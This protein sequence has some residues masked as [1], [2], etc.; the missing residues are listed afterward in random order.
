MKVF[1]KALA[2]LLTVLL[3]VTT[4]IVCVSAA[5][6]NEEEASATSSGITVHYKASGTA[7]PTIYYWNSLPT[8][9]TEPD[10]PG[11]KM[12]L[13]TNEGENWY[14]YSF[15]DI[16]KINMLFIESGNQS[17]ELT[18]GSSGEYWYKDGI[19]YTSNPEQLDPLTTD[20]REDTIYFVITTRFYDGDSGN[21]VHCWDDS[22]ANNPDSDPA[23]RGDFKGLIEKLDYI[24][25]LGFSAIWITPVVTNA[26]GYDYHGY[27]AFDF[28]T[29]DVRYESE[30]AT[31]QDLINAAHAKGM[32]IVQDVV[33]QHTGNFGEKTF[34]NLFDKQYD[35]IQDLADIETSMIP[36]ET[37]L[38]EYGL[39]SA[40]EYYAQ[41]PAVQHAERLKLIKGQDPSN[42]NS[43]L[44]GSYENFKQAV[45]YDKQQEERIS[46]SDTYNANN[47]Y[48]T[49]Y[50]RN[51]NFDDYASKYFQIA[52]DC[53]DLNTENPEVADKLV[54]FYSNYIGMGVDA[55]RVDTLRHMSRLSLNAMYNDRLNAAGGSSF[56]MFGEC[57]TRYNGVW[58]RD[59]ASESAPF[60]TWDETDT[61][62]L[63]N[64]NYTNTSEA[65]G[66]NLNLTLDHWIDNYDTSNQ[67]TSDNALLDG[68]DYHTPDYT[69]ASGMGVIDFP[70]HWEFQSASGAF[71]VA[72]SSDKYYNDATWNVVYVDSHDYG[73]G[74]FDRFDGGT[75]AWAENMCLMF[76]F[77]GIPCLYYG[78]EVEFQKGVIIDKG[79]NLPLSQTGRAYFGDY[80]EGS[81]SATDYGEYTASG[82]VEDTL[83]S[84]LSQQL[85]KLN[86]IRRAVPALQKGQYSVDD[87]TGDMCFKRGYTDPDSGEKSF[88]CVAVT[89]AGTFKNI[90]NGTY[91]DAVTGDTKTVTNGTLTV[92]APGKGNCR[93]YVLS[94]NG[95]T[96]IDGKIGETTT[97]LK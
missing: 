58:Y 62:Y 47:Y 56:Y 17:K 63:S 55:F 2:V 42:S 4:G 77:R 22:T 35:T 75:Q 20:L 69:E 85:I 86:K 40:E 19:W 14:T 68:N 61:S 72:V 51:S 30:G 48:H 32:K 36:N 23:W 16:T 54:E 26:S 5:S 70:M 82:T 90:P 41:T 57:C 53:V 93:V 33:L 64:W 18:R 96:G 87:V 12:T 97:Y 43:T 79:T 7:V 76:T 89:N 73:P 81:V 52:G 15:S 39:N 11:T 84:T 3:I 66:E 25:A 44:N 24:K 95:Y 37:L 29:V 31:Y 28:S 50:W 27:H 67:P 83:N 1:K 13:D 88:A 71:N 34:A 92:S 10:Y 65:V 60:Y 46:T 21:N 78:S 6:T 94:S 91:I 38:N 74:T 59:M 49:G 8:N 9:I 80:L 45:E